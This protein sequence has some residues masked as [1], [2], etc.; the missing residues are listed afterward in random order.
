MARPARSSSPVRGERGIVGITPAK[1]KVRAPTFVVTLLGAI[2][3][4]SLAVIGPLALVGR[5]SYRNR[6]LFGGPRVCPPCGLLRSL[7]RLRVVARRP[8]LGAPMKTP[9]RGMPSRVRMFS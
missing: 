4:Q 6:F 1:A 7:A 9:G 8:V 3:Y 5:T 2:G